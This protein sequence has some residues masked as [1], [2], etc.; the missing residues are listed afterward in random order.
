ML[1]KHYSFR[2]L[3]ISALAA[4]FF[5]PHFSASKSFC[6]NPSFH[7]RGHSDFPIPL[8]AFEFVLAALPPRSRT[9]AAGRACRTG[10]CRAEAKRRR[11]GFRDSDLEFYLPFSPRAEQTD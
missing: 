6:Q 5:C 4:P 8:S 7:F 2:Y 3:L 1:F 9:V 10:S 11:V